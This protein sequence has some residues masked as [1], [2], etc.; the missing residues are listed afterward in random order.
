L[1][2]YL[3]NARGSM[4]SDIVIYYFSGTRNTFRAVSEISAVFREKEIETTVIPI[5]ENRYYSWDADLY[6]FAFPIYSKTMFPFIWKFL[7]NLPDG[8]GAHAFLLDTHNG[9]PAVLRPM[10]KLLKRKGY[11][12]VGS[13][14]LIM[15]KNISF[16]PIDEEARIILTEKAMVR[17]REFAHEILEKKTAWGNSHQGSSFI[18][19]FQK[20]TGIPLMTSKLFYTLSINEEKCSNCGICEDLCPVKNIRRGFAYYIMGDH[21]ELCFRCLAHCPDKAI[22]LNGKPVHSVK[23]TE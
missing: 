1:Q 17:A 16:E 13:C 8:R 5:D 9:T 20:S 19:W 14:E 11:K 15:P 4:Y 6:G 10:Y 2:W 3:L 22:E 7:E 21:C 23:V 12:P 18:A